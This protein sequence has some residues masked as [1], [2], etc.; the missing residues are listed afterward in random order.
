MFVVIAYGL[1]GNILLVLSSW[2]QY[3]MAQQEQSHRAT[4]DQ[5]VGSD[6]PCVR[7]GQPSSVLFRVVACL[8][9]CTD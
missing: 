4:A 9:P 5:S 8:M 2:V 3:S 7:D 6:K 1:Q